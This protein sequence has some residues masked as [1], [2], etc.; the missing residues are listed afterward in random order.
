MFEVMDRTNVEGYLEEKGYL[1][2]NVQGVMKNTALKVYTDDVHNPNGVVI[3]EGYFHYVYTE[4]VAFVEAY[5]EWSKDQAFHGF[6]GTTKVVR[7]YFFKKHL[8]QWDNPCHQYH[9]EGEGFDLPPLESLSVMDA[10][11]VDGHYEYQNDDSLE[12]IKRAILKRPT[13]CLRQGG[14]IISFVLL[15]DD[16]SIGYM[17]TLPEYRGKGH[18][19]L[20]TKDIINKTL[21]DHRLPYIQ[22]VHGNDKSMGLAMKAGFKQHGDVYWFGIIRPKA[23]DF[24]GYLDYYEQIY[25]ERAKSVSLK[26]HLMMHHVPLEVTLTE[27][28]FVYKG[29][30]YPVK[31]ELH[32]DVYHVLASE[33]DEALLIS[34]LMALMQNE[35]ECCLI[36]IVMKD[37]AFKPI[38]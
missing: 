32:K 12:K 9:Y 25:Q 20:L 38:D 23:V 28:A 18:A 6:S 27:N 10:E 4:S 26:C 22:I 37:K 33:M 16:D 3:K 36:N 1:S 19:Y 24:K 15:H 34:G 35:W 13:S 14:Q 17:Y 29:V 30:S 5:D 11:Y 7:D 31:W 8:I 2:L 21:A